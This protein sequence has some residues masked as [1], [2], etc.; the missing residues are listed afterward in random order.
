[1]ITRDNFGDNQAATEQ[2][3][4]DKIA[5]VNKIFDQIGVSFHIE[6]FSYTN[7]TEW[8]VLNFNNPTIY[9]NLCS[10]LPTGTGL[11]VYVVESIIYTNNNNNVESIGGFNFDLG[12]VIR[13][14]LSA[15]NTAHEFG[16]QAGWRDIYSYNDEA[17]ESNGQ[18]MPPVSGNIKQ[19]W[20]PG[21]WTGQYNH[22]P[23]NLTQYNLIMKCLMYG[24]INTE[25]AD[26]PTG[27]VYGI[28]KKYVNGVLN[29]QKSLAPIGSD[30]KKIIIPNH[31]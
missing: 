21:D 28:W 9:S 19:E 24:Y 7:C 18:A 6:S 17:K 11:E 3:C 1:M 14:D 22:Y 26:M 10:S 2:E 8:K 16:H 20:L 12:T 23:A 13:G 30:K 5:G 31:K 4:H 27:D 29:W 25:N 15:R